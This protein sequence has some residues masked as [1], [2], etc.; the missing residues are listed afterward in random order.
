VI[1]ESIENYFPLAK[2]IAGE[3]DNIPGFPIVEIEMTAQEARQVRHHQHHI[4][5]LNMPCGNATTAEELIERIPAFHSRD[6]NDAAAG[7]ESDKRLALAMEA[8]SPRLRLVAEGIGAGK[9]YS[10]IGADLGISKQAAHKLAGAAMATLREKLH[11]MG[12]GGIDTL[13]L[14]KSHSAARVASS[15][16]DDF[17]PQP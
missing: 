12:F 8:L 16:I 13:G 15:P 10:E 9:S 7:R 5:D 4:Y 11:S 3:F 1:E 6:V 2:K 17:S 14:L